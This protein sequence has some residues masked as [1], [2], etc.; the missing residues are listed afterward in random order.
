MHRNLT[1]PKAG[2]EVSLKAEIQVKT[3]SSVLDTAQGACWWKS[4][5]ATYG[6]SFAQGLVQQQSAALFTGATSTKEQRSRF[7]RN[8]NASTLKHLEFA[9]EQPDYYRLHG[10]IP[11]YL[12]KRGLPTM[13]LILLVLLE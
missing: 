7:Q 4:T 11:L 8:W 13:I 2:S 5:A 1:W 12:S 3:T 6:S 10:T 9:T